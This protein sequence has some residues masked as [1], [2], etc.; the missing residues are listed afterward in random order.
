MPPAPRLP[1]P[2]PDPELKKDPALL[3]RG[4][5]MEDAALIASAL[6][7][8]LGTL[9][10][11]LLRRASAT[12]P[13]DVPNARSLHT[14]P[15]PR[16]GAFA[17]WLG[18]VPAAMVYPPSIPG[19][20]IGWLPAWLALVVVSAQ[21]DAREAGVG[22]AS[23]LTV[24]AGASLW[25]A[26]WLLG[27]AAG[28]LGPAPTIFWIAFTAL[29]I[30]WSSNLFNFMD[31]VDGLATIMG[32]V[33]FA[34]YGAAALGSGAPPDAAA[35][36]SARASAPALLAL[37]AA[38]LPF[39][40]V[41]RPPASM[42]IGDAGA[43]PLGFLAGAFGVAGTIS[44]WW[45]AWFPLL[46]FLPFLADATLTLGGRMLRRERWWEGHRRHYYQRLHQLGAGHAGTLAA[47]T[48]LM[49]GTSVTAVAF[50]AWAPAT[51]WWALTAWIAVVLMLFAAI[52]YHW[53]KKTNPAA[54]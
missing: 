16:A 54:R 9:G 31:G 44:N 41:N 22:I 45:P 25:A 50:R 11:W 17:V 40:V 48:A 30:A 20:W 3:A 35:Q 13:P 24:H 46:V 43:V 5:P 47:Y 6:A 32:I 10:I 26:A 23:R 14:A 18:F 4:E 36:A 39:F 15:V 21:D 29:V 33:G 53:R 52:D 8:G 42:F 49:I 1:V 19:G 27:P 28:T 7:A 34:A 51:G 38:L 2:K 12:L 37:A